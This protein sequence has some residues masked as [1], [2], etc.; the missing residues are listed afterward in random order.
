MKIRSK[1]ILAF[2]FSALSLVILTNGLFYVSAKKNLTRQILNHLESVASIQ[3]HRLHGIVAQNM[4]RWGLVA[5]R[6]QLRIILEQFSRDPKREYQ[7]RMNTI[8]RDAMEPIN[9]FKDISL[10][11]LDGTIIASTDAEKIGENHADAVYFVQGRQKISVDHFFFDKDKRLMVALTGPLHLQN[12]VIGVL[13]IESVVENIASSI[14]DYTG[15]GN[16]G[17]TILAKRDEH[18]DAL[19]LMP[20]RF[21]KQAALRLVIPKEEKDKPITQ[22]FLGIFDVLSDSVDYRGIPVLAATRLVE[23]SDWGIV[24]KIDRDEAF[25][26]V[27]QMRNLLVLVVVASLI[28]VILVALYF[29]RSITQPIIKLT[30]VAKNIAQGQVAGRADETLRDETGVLAKAFNTMTDNLITTHKN[31]ESKV[32]QLREREERISLLLNST[33]EGI[34]GLD[35]DGYCTFCNPSCL[36]LLGYTDDRELLGQHMHTLIHHTK[37]DGTE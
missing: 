36:R 20:T 9:D 23:D 8:L 30:E 16:T 17:E 5:S 21:D 10:F 34:Y 12:K 7:H 37:A 14:G 28:F 24:V 31:L 27:R 19:F 2:L 18:G 6:T 33:A 29:S 4:E 11:T 1:L 32:K 13:V 3:H 35:Q 22:I 15:L 25:A 26:P